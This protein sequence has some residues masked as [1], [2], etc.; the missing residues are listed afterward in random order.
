MMATDPMSDGGSSGTIW[1]PP[2]GV[3][4]SDDWM[5]ARENSPL[6]GS[7]PCLKWVREEVD[8]KLDAPCVEGHH[9][10]GSLGQTAGLKC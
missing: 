4:G 10:M 3:D 2:S 9:Q 7:S 5:L 1:S 6:K 8:Q